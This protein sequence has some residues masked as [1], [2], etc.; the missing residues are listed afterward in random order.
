MKLE[1]LQVTDCPNVAVLEQRLRDAL[2]DAGAEIEIEHRVIDD[3]AEAATAGMTGSPTL[4]VD[5]RDP[6]AV[7][8]QPPSVS[9]R[10]YR[11]EDG[12]L[13]GAPTITALCAAL[14]MTPASGSAGLRRGAGRGAR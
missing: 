7:P 8:G 11:R 4:L 14:G 5:G 9:C 12:G 6:F 13:D 2:T 10:L 3:A 1:I